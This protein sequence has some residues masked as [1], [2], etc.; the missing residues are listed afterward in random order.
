[1]NIYEQR[2][3]TTIILSLE[4]RLDAL[5]APTLENQLQKI[6]ETFT[7]VILD[8]SE[9]TFIS[10]MGIRVMIQ[11]FKWMNAKKGKFVIKNISEL[12]RDVFEISGL[13]D[14]FVQ[15]EKFVIIQ[16]ERNENR[17]VFSLAGNLNQK[18]ALVLNNQLR[19]LENEGFTT[20]TLDFAA[21]NSISLEGRSMLESAQ[22]RI[23]EKQGTLVIQN[24]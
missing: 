6:R 18:A 11:G 20:I 4:G 12:V 5:S 8:L 21:V 17:I 10:S 7:E 23:R 1:M 14:L 19:Q 24:I 16:K 15:D 22:K 13:I 9:L 3:G 2:Q